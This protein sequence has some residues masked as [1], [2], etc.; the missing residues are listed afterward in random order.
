VAIDEQGTAT[1]IWESV[2]SVGATIYSST[3]E[4]GASWSQ[5]VAISGRDEDPSYGSDPNVVADSDGTVTAIWH[6]YYEVGINRIEGVRREIGGDWSQPVEIGRS[7]GAIEEHPLAVDPDG[8]VTVAWSRGSRIFSSVYDSV[9]PELNDIA[10][11]VTGV[12][13][14]PVAMSVDPLDDWPP[15]ATVWD[16]GDGGA[17]SGATVEHCYGSA[18][19]RTV[20][21]TG[22]D[23]AA[24]EANASRTIAIEPDPDLAVGVDPCA[25]PEPPEEPEPPI[26]PDPSSNPGIP[27]IPGPFAPEEHDLPSPVAP[28]VSSLRQSHSRWRRPGT[29]G[30]SYLPVGTSFH[31]QLDRAAQM[32]LAFSRIAPGR[33]EQARGTLHIA[34]EAGTNLYRFAG[35]IRSHML[36]PGRYRLRLIATADGMSS[37]AASI[38]FTIL[39]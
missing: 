34:G 7:N 37:A 19:E 10:V 2:D 28:V 5:P 4:E 17:G 3:G 21:I 9:T 35:K 29:R 20:T 12:V 32:Q 14:Q 33:H 23:G 27:G 31:F 8:Y 36:A 26:E 1:V 38:R 39:G 16:F 13:G 18:G 22:T 30:R 11:P 24:N 6:F 25:E 15:V